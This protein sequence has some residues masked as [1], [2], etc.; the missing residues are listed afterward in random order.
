MHVENLVK[1]GMAT[2]SRGM[3]K[4][5]KH[6]VTCSLPPALCDFSRA[7]LD[8]YVTCRM[9]ALTRQAIF[10]YVR[11]AGDKELTVFPYM[12]TT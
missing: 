2:L 12:Q 9:R 4:Y 8:A 1:C 10:I 7:S 6:Y 3:V 5:R 11:T